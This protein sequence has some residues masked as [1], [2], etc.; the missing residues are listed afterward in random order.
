MFLPIMV[1]ATVNRT[2]RGLSAMILAASLLTAP[3][4]QA[5]EPLHVGYSDWPG[6]VAW[7]VAID[8]GW[9]KKA[10]VNAQFE[11]FDYSASMDAFSAGK[12]DGVM[13]TNGDALVMG[14]NGAK[15]VMILL[16]DYSNGNDI[17]VGKPGVKSLA[18]LKGKKIGLEVGLVEHLLLIDGLRKAGIKE[19]DVTLVNAKTNETPQVLASGDVAAIGAWQPVAGQAMRGAPGAKALYSSA[20]QPG[21]I[22]DV[23]AVSPTSLASR[24]ADWLKLVSVW[25]KIVD[26]IED[27]KTQPDAVAIMAVKAGVSPDVFTSI[28]K[29]TK[30]LKLAD[31]RK[32]MVDAVGFGSLYGSSR[33]ADEFNLKFDVYKQPQDVKTY[34]DPALTAGK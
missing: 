18:D 20:D 30:F 22:Y 34:I 9:L 16:T 17:I 7:Q 24:R 5:A 26:Y 21:L 15:S 33:H 32:V 13:V 14:G 11:W 8:K 28:L 31:G 4:A 2:C 23:I 29:G 19:S 3:V 10:G 27:P 1:T 12:L 6:W 25:D